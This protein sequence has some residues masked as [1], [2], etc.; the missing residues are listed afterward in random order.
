MKNNIVLILC[1]I[2]GGELLHT[3]YVF[4]RKGTTPVGV[5][6]KGSP[7]HFW[8]IVILTFIFGATGLMMGIVGILS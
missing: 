4:L 1:I 2:V 7:F 5:S 8:F 6:R 3:A